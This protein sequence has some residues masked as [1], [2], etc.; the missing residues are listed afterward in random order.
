LTRPRIRQDKKTRKWII[1][2][3]HDKKQHRLKGFPTKKAADARA[4]E[5]DSEVRKGIHTPASASGTIEDACKDWVQ[6]ARDLKREKK[7]ILQYENHTDLH[8]IP[9][10]STPTKEG[11]KPIWPGKLGDLKLAK[12]T[13]PIAYAVQ[14]ELRRRLSPEMARK[15]MVSFKAAINEAVNTGKVAYNAAATIKPEREERTSKRKIQ[16]GIDFPFR[17]EVAAVV[18]A[19]EGRLA[20]ADPYTGFLWPQGV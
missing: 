9:L 16:P 18:A 3:Y 17:E 6:R 4:S 13:A 2:Y 12:L 11:D 5:I 19:I 7:T 1:E 14:R 8:I 10:N 15:V 20:S